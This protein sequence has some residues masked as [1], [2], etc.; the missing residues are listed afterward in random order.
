MTEKLQNI[1]K[2]EVKKLPTE[3]QEVINSF[4]WIKTTE[5]IG[6]KFFLTEDEVEDLQVETL[7]VLVGIEDGEFYAQNI[8][9]N[10]GTSRE[11]A[12]KISEEVLQKIFVP[13]TD[14]IIENAKKSLQTKNPSWDK[15]INFIVSGGDYSAFIERREGEYLNETELSLPEFSIKNQN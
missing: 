6:K 15:T 4:D 13:V 14:R 11:E 9:D 7:L 10:V 3:A 8:E 5:E 1:I 12:E 2:E